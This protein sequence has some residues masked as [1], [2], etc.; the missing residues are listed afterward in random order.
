M[1]APDGTVTDGDGV[2]VVDV[3]F[4]GV[5]VT[6][7]VCALAFAPPPVKVVVTKNDKIIT[8]IPDKINLFVYPPPFNDP[9]SIREVSK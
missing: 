4:T 3:V 5:T 6:V 1:G 8:T 7:V 2:S 9:K